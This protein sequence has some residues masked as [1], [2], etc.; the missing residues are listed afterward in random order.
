MTSFSPTLTP[1]AN[2]SKKPGKPGRPKGRKP[3]YPLYARIKPS[4]G[5]AFDAYVESIQPRTST[6]AVIEMILEQYLHAQGVWPP[7]PDASA[8][9][10]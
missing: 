10:R 3:T 4:L 2:N 5:E 1:M 7:I 9:D 6:T 8:E